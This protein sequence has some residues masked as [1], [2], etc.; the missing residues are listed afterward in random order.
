MSLTGRIRGIAFDL[1]GVLIH[2]TGCHRSAFEQV[3]QGWGIGDFDYSRYAG[4]RTP[5]VIAAEFR[6]HR[7][8]ADAGTIRAAAERKTTLARQMLAEINPVPADCRGVLEQ[9]AKAYRLALASSGSSGSVESFLRVNRFENVFQ[10]VLSGEDVSNAKP[11]PE[12]YRR[13][14]AALGLAPDACVVVEDAVSGIEAARG[15]GADA[16][17]ITGTCQAS[18]L[19]E[20]GARHVIDSLSEL[21]DLVSSL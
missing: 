6:R 19:R 7:I 15:A 10:S 3:L 11:D 5:E 2:S 9:L 20:A 12:V 18:T 21:P 13:S 17:G 4:W 1:D 14:F 8:P 16:I